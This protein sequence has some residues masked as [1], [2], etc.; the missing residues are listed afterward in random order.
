MGKIEL[1]VYCTHEELERNIECE[2]S[3]ETATGYSFFCPVCKREIFLG[4][5]GVK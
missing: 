2:L 1:K 3:Q 4:E 5:K